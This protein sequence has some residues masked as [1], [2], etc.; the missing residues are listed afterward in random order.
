VTEDA[1]VALAPVKSAAGPWKFWGTTLWG[2]A[3]LAVGV[4]ICV[5]GIVGLLFQLNP[6]PDISDA[7]LLRLMFAHEWVLIVVVAAGYGCGCGILVLAIWLSRLTIGDYLALRIPRLSDVL[8]GLAGIAVL[9]VAYSYVARLSG[10]SSA[11]Q[12][13]LDL[14]HGAN[15]SG[16][17]SILAI[18]L[19]V[20]APVSEEVF[21][22]GFLLRGWTASRLGP[23]G[24]VVLTSLVWTALH[25][26][27]DALALIDIFFAGLWLGWIR[28]RSGSTLATMILH[29]SQNAAALALA[30]ISYPPA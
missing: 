14:Y 11:S 16:G 29:A 15:V 4:I 30:M 12:F 22:R 28:L 26:G 17:L 27:Y 21:V 1:A 18:A 8:I 6:S 2:L 3:M 24:A 23:I 7:D 5:A 13:L 25:A 9:S 20:L 19:V 10:P